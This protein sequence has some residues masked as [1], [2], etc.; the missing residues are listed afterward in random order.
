MN[1]ISEIKKHLRKFPEIVIKED[2]NYLSATI[3]S[4]NGFEVWFSEDIEEYTVGFEGWHQ[5]FDK[6][7]VESAIECFTFGL[8]DKCRLKVTSRGGKAYKWQMEAFE[9]GEWVPY[10]TTGLL[11]SKFWKNATVIYLSNNI[12]SLKNE[13]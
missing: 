7:E 11:V 13:I 12:I 5:H 3:D 9:G 8:S 10:S 6:S 2:S 4:P 1:P